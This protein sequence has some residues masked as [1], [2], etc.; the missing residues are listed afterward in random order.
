M[1]V[2]RSYIE[3]ADELN[4]HGGFVV[5]GTFMPMRQLP[6]CFLMRFLRRATTDLRVP[7]ASRL[8]SVSSGHEGSCHRWPRFR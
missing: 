1:G 5:Y 7:C 4:T 3:A 8:A 2:H 6:S